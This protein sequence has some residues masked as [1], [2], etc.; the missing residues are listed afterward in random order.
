MARDIE[1]V[2]RQSKQV[3]RSFLIEFQERSVQYKADIV[4]P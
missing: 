2:R 3:G 1:A 4:V